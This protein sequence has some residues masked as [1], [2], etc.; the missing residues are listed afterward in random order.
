[1]ATLSPRYIKDAAEAWIVE[2][3][4]ATMGQP[5]AQDR[6]FANMGLP[7]TY[8]HQWFVGEVPKWAVLFTEEL[9]RAAFGMK[10]PESGVAG[11]V[12]PPQSL[13]E[14]QKRAKG[15]AKVV[16][17]KLSETNGVAREFIGEMYMDFYRMVEQRTLDLIKDQ[18]LMGPGGRL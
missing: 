8:N 12:K 10:I 2:K 18:P 16:D 1:M 5:N 14:F 15:V 4:M 13:E 7:E 9:E 6:A 11:N 17:G 3:R